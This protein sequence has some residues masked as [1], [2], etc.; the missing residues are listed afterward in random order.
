MKLRPILLAF[1]ALLS[2]ACSK[3]DRKALV[4]RNNPKVTEVNPLHSLNLGNG[5]FCAVFDA[6]GLQTF[7]EFYKDG[8]SLGTYSEWGW[9]SFPNTEN[10]SEDEILENHPL[11]GHPGGVYAVQVGNGMSE[12]SQAAAEWI[13]ANPHR[14]HL[15]NIGFS[16]MMPE[17]ISEVDQ[18]LDMWNGELISNF[19]W[20]GSPVCVRTVCAGEEDVIASSIKSQK[21]IELSLRF[22]YPT[23]VH[24]DDAS[25]WGSDGRHNTEILESSPGSAVFKRTV[26]DSIY[27]LVLSWSGNAEIIR[28]SRNSFRLVPESAE[29]SF[30]A[31]FAETPSKPSACSFLLA[32]KSASKMWNEYWKTTGVIDFSHCT[33]RSAPLLERRVLLSQYLMRSQEAQNFPPAETGMT[34]NSWYGKFHLEMLMWHSFHYATWNKPELLAKQLDWYFKA[35]PVAKQIAERQGFEG[36]RWMKMT[37]PSGKEAPSDIGSYIIWQQPHPIYMAELLY[38]AD[39]SEAVLDK[40]YNIVEESAKF[41]ADF[42][43]YDVTNDRYIIEGACAANESLNEDR[44]LNPSFELAYWHFAL[45]LAQKWRERKG[46][47]RISEWDTICAKLS[48]L[49]LSPDGIYLPAEKGPGVPDFANNIPAEEPAGAP[50]GGYVNGQRPKSGPKQAAPSSGSFYVKGTSSENLLAYGMLPMSRLVDKER[51]NATLERAAENWGWTTGTW[52]WNYPSLVM[53]ATRLYR[54]DIA[55]RAVTMDDRSDLLLPSG[56]N[57]RSTTLRMYLPG[58][59]GLLLAVGMMCAGWDGCEVENPGFPKDG[60]WDVRWEGLSPMP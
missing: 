55:I 26:D 33:N 23:G 17:E 46:E 35:M 27:Y 49:S 28:T 47:E 8:L 37:D 45:Q 9:H 48:P 42:V 51:L 36:V 11:P 59:G 1:V 56:N 5:E 14:M 57:Y 10:Y 25:S 24:T 29:F 40:Y 13:R 43:S 3:I 21:P 41:V 39:P 30:A 4:T 22:P 34:Y 50:A 15:G 6:T 31:A 18:C 12:R 60:S 32:Q 19:K 53:N 20:N 52:S 38:R 16:N 2:L 58:N 7:P 54:S 44:T